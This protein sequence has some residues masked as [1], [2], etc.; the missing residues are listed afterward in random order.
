MRKNLWNLLGDSEEFCLSDGAGQPVCG[1]Y[2]PITE[3]LG[4]NL[5]GI[6]P[7]RICTDCLEEADLPAILA[8][9]ARATA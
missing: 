8:A 7:E 2:R 6:A 5:E 4:P 1:R 9:K 3:T